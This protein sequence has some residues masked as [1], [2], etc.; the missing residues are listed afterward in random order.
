MNLSMVVNIPHVMPITCNNAIYGV[1]TKKKT[2]QNQKQKKKQQQQ[3]QQS[4]WS[5]K[6][7]IQQC[8]LNK[9]KN[10][11]AQERATSSP[12]HP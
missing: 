10:S 9:L 8:I 4:M 7:K 11:A 6:R 1:V 3:Q 5:P 12:P 2:K